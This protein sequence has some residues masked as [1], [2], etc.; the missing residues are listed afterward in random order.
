M[1]KYTVKYI[2]FFI[3]ASID[4]ENFTTFKPIEE[5]NKLEK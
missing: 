3:R 2:D 5:E 1:K 4:P